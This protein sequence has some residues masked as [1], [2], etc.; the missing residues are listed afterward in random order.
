MPSDIGQPRAEPATRAYRSRR[1]RSRTGSI[2]RASSA[3]PV[4]S[5]RLQAGRQVLGARSQR[6]RLRELRDRARAPHG[7]PGP[8]EG[9]RRTDRPGLDLR[10]RRGPNSE[11]GPAAVRLVGARLLREPLVH[12]LA[13]RR[14]PLRRLRRRQPR[15]GSRTRQSQPDRADARRP[16]PAPDR[17][18]RQVAAAAERAGDVRASSRTGSARRSSIA[19][20]SRWASTRTTPSSSGGWRRRWSSSPRTSR[21]RT[22]RPPTSCKAVV[23]EE[24]AA[25]HAARPR[26]VPAPLLLAGPARPARARRREAGPRE[27]RRQARRLDRRRGARRSLHVP[28]LPRRS[29]SRAARQ[30]LRPAVRAR[31]S[32]PR[33]PAPGRDRSS[34]ATAG[35]S[36]SSIPLTPERVP[37]SRRS[38]RT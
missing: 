31:R 23:R 28:G 38:S 10:S 9:A 33:S 13:A 35:I 37:R 19:R 34:R 18:R 29:H 1:T 21:R 14:V 36:S 3:T 5:D 17:L 11:R 30:G 26:H 7:S 20:P 12:F 24:H 15:P 27:A 32:S 22:S 25:I 16:A 6:V 8:L 2:A 4:R